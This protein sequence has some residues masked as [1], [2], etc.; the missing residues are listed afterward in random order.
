VPL[1]DAD[2]A[3]MREVQAEHRPTAATLSRQVTTR[4]PT[5]GSTSTWDEGT[6]VDVR[7]SAPTDEVPAA[8]AERYG[9]AAL[10]KVVLDLVS[11]VRSGDRLT[12]SPTEVYQVVTDGTPDRWATAQVVWAVRQTWPSR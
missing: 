2:L 5:G 12:V 7:L 8:L 1:D 11:D 10:V 4:T 6:P 9:V 3:Y